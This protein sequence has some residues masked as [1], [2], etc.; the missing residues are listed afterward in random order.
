M[1]LDPRPD[2]LRPAAKPREPSLLHYILISI[3]LFCSLLY[4]AVYAKTELVNHIYGTNYTKTD[5]LL[6]YYG[7]KKQ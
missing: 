5:I 2:Y 4:L 1:T 6:D 7:P 3:I